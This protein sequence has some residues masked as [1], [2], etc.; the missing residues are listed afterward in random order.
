MSVSAR[1]PEEG[2]RVPSEA[3]RWRRWR[4]RRPERE[5]GL[6]LGAALALAAC[7]FE[8][9][10][11]LQRALFDHV[12]VLDVTQSMNV[13][14][15]QLDDR[16]VS[17][18]AFA[19]QAVRDALLRLPCGSKLGL[20]LFTEY[21]S[22]LLLQPVEVCA[23]L[24]ELRSTL[25]RID[26]RMAWTGNSEVAKGLYGG[27]AVA[28]QLPDTPSLVFVTDGQEAPPV[29]PRHRPPFNGKAGEVSGLIVGVGGLTPQPIPKTDPEGRPL[30]F[31]G[32]DEVQQTDPYSR[33][34]GGSVGGEAMV[35]GPDTAT[36]SAL[37]TAPA[38]SEHLSSLREAYL[39]LLAGETGLRF[40]R[41]QQTSD[42]GTAMTA[43]D[44]ARPVPARLDL[45]PA[46]GLLALLLLVLRHVPTLPAWRLP[47]RGPHSE[48]PMT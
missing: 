29:N 38:G 37:P 30:G 47:R 2:A 46:L 24:Q 25:A 34:R 27:L 10:W 39:R 11:P 45:R 36:P 48:R 33:G 20:G 6:L 40:L 9:S 14:D 21:R 18:L 23:N 16:P 42:L 35:D 3:P 19:R 12:V 1:P 22:Y 4:W 32:A 41:L 15:Q 43:S 8:P 31:W 44:L 28:R 5:Q 26:G 7:L 17:R 13:A